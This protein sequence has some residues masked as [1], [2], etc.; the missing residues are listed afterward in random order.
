MFRNSCRLLTVGRTYEGSQHPKEFVLGEFPVHCEVICCHLNE[1]CVFANVILTVSWIGRCH[2]ILRILTVVSILH[3][4]K[5]EQGGA[6]S[7]VLDMMVTDDEGATV[8]VLCLH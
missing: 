6:V 1:Y 4:G 2:K 8:Q 7:F 3:T 5:Y